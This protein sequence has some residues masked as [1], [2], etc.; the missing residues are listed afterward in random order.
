MKPPSRRTRAQVPVI[1][2]TH[3]ALE[4]AAVLLDI[5]VSTL[6]AAYPMITDHD[7]G[8]LVA[9]AGEHIRAA[10]AVISSVVEVM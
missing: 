5:A 3:E 10:R 2:S 9:G 7:A 1:E 4:R 8:N 6:D